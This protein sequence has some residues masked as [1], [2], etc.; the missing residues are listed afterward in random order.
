M[1]RRNGSGVRASVSVIFATMV[2]LTSGCGQPEVET[3]TPVA[4]GALDA[5]VAVTGGEVQG[6]PAVGNPDIVLFQ[7]V[8]YA[9][10]PVGDLR[11]QPPQPVVAWDGVRDATAPG[12]MCVQAGPAF[13]RAPTTTADDPESEDCLLLNIWAPRPTEEPLPVMVWVHGGGFFNGES[14]LPLYEGTG[15]AE[16]DVVVVTIN[17][18]LN[19]FGFM[20]HPALSAES[21]HGASG[22]Y[23]LMDVVAALEWVRDNIS[24]F[25]GDPSQVTLFG[26]SAGGGAVMSVMLMPQSEGLFQRAISESTWVYGWDRGLS[27]PVGDWDSAE[28]QGVRVAESLGATGD[29]AL[30]TL[31]AASA[32]AVQEA[33]NANMGNLLTRTEYIWAPNVDGWTIPSDPLAMYAAGLQHDVPLITGMNAGEGASI[34][35]RSGVD[36]AASFESHVR[37]V[38]AAAADEILAEYDVTSPDTAMAQVAHLVTDMYFAGP[39]RAQV[40][41]HTQVSSPVWLYQFSRVP[42]TALGTIV[43]AAYHGGEVAYVFDT[44]DDGPAPTGAPPH[45][46]ATHGAWTET[47]RQLSETMMAYWTQFAATGN[48]NRADLP[49]WPEFDLATDHYL[50]LGDTLST[51]EGLHQAGERLFK[52]FETG[53]RAETS[54]P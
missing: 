34:A 35:V 54:A 41:A 48:P 40:A 7:G 25:G 10:P 38:Y 44:M 33:A 5:P 30:A 19:V 12:P 29:T 47:D 50:D 9:A 16:R 45:P 51:G 20:A 11:W 6:A 21:P 36:D 28:A 42:P 15:L 1:S 26:E 31:R 8:P 53:R 52:A 3:E 39:V 32:A 27:E 24:A 23:G 43:G 49:E 18:R 22:N 14:S 13:A 17:Y 4:G 2:A 37:T 46:M